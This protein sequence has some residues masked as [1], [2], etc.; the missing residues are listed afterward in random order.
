[1]CTFM[2]MAIEI[3]VESPITGNG[4]LADFRKEI[5]PAA[6]ICFSRSYLF[7]FRDAL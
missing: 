7:M 4:R 3:T 2:Y 1:M 6:L 5:F